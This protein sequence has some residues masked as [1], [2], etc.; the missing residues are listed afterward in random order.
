MPPGLAGETLK[1]AISR[2]CS[3][4]DVE[5]CHYD[6]VFALA[7]TGKTGKVFELEGKFTAFVSYNRLIIAEKLYK[8]VKNGV[9]E[10]SVPG[11]ARVWED[12]IVCSE[13]SRPAF[14]SAESMTQYFDADKLSG[15]VIRTRRQG[16]F[17][18]PLGAAGGK[19]LKDWFIDKKV[20]SF[21]RDAVPVLARG[22]E[23]LWVI[24]FGI[25]ESVRVKKST[26]RIAELKYL[27]K[28]YEDRHGG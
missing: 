5:K 24:G 22:G 12:E 25:S 27:P 20:P 10:L 17:F 2:V 16:D 23:V 1:I 4:K 19:K 18:R 15:A 3:L 6:A 13:A 14:T 26:K 21:L 11:A 28:K 7:R 9:F 8:I